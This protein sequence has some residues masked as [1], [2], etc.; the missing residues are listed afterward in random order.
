M[1]FGVNGLLMSVSQ[2]LFDWASER[3]YRY[4]KQHGS[5]RFHSNL[6]QGS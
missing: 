1:L 3:K 2:S 5:L 6:E 4:V